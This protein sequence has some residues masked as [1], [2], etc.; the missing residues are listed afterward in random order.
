MTTLLFYLFAALALGGALGMV[1]GRTPIA[2]LLSLVSSLFSLAAIYV[3]LEAHFIAAIQIIVY[4]GAI[5]VLF[6]FVIMLLNLGHDYQRDLREFGWIAAG[7]IVAGLGGYAVMRALRADDAVTDMGGSIL[8]ETALREFNAVG[9]VA[10][11]MFRSYMVPFE[12]TS[13]L[14]LVAIV[15]AVLLAKRRV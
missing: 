14:L 10:V 9:A 12:L 1:L 5:M 2:S 4:A 15:G 13:I 8:I 6:L 3:L 7:S 11:P